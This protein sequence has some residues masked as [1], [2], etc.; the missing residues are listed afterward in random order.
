[1]KNNK[2]FIYPTDTVWGIGSP[3]IDANGNKEI[4]RIKKTSSDKPLT[5]L[6]TNIDQIKNYLNVDSLFNK[7]G[8]DDLF[9]QEITIGLPVS[10]IINSVIPDF[11]LCKSDY[12]YFRCLPF[13]SEY[14]SIPVTTTSLNITGEPPIATTEEARSFYDK[15]K[16][17]NPHLECIWVD[18]DLIT[19]SGNPST[20]ICMK[21]NKFEVVRKGV[22][23]DGISRK[24]NILSA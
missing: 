21:N 24:L 23:V 6:F 16:C 8:L 1:M 13:L 5:V 3:I 9:L 17:D 7:E 2:V 4:S 20:I 19:M 10:Y 12:I 18:G 11:I 15:V 14:I 22:F